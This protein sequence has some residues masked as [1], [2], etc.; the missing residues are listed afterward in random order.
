MDM[1]TFKILSKCQCAEVKDKNKWQYMPMQM[2]FDVKQLGRCKARL[3]IGRHIIDATGHDLYASN[4]KTISAHALMLIAAA[5]RYDVLC[6]DIGNAYLYASNTIPVWV[7]LSEEFTVF[8]K[9]IKPGTPASIEQAQ[10]G[11]PIGAN[12]W[13]A[14][15][16]DTLL[17]MGFKPTHFD[18]DVWI[19]KNGKDHYD[20]LGTHTDDIMC[21]SN[22]AQEIMEGLQRTYTIKKVAPPEHHLGCDYKQGDDGT[23][24]IGTETYVREALKRIKI[25]LG[26]EDKI[27]E[28]NDKPQDCLGKEGN[29][30]KEKYKPEVENTPVLDLDGKRKYQ[31]LIGIAQW[32]IT[33]GRMD[34]CFAMASLSW[35]SAMPREGHLKAVI[36][37]FKYLNGL[38]AKW[39]KFDPTEHKPPAPLDI[40]KGG[41]LEV[42]EGKHDWHQQY[43]D[44]QEDLDPRLPELHG[45]EIDIAVY[46]DLNWAHDEKTQRSIM[47]IIRFLGNTP[48]TWLSK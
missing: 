16:S 47:G 1:K 25:I 43:P 6:G 28:G 48:V 19:K 30:M 46:F 11:L 26:H 42:M 18:P 44:A 33:C 23:W 20:Y 32:L 21:V 17:S 45:A 12:R 24:S 27:V 39:I 13:H 22:R 37:I 10:Y 9:L 5:N 3:V 38:P 14:H 34:L 40:P 29:P 15:L 8:D 2:I 7:R 35:F 41:G 36:D 31:Q 4:M